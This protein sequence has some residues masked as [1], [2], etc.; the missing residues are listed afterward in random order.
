MSNESYVN[1]LKE[2]AMKTISQRVTDELED[3]MTEHVKQYWI[4]IAMIMKTTE[5]K[6]EVPKL[7]LEFF[8]KTPQDDFSFMKL[9]NTEVLR[10]SM[11]YLEGEEKIDREKCKT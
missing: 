8:S 9:M 7:D 10:N 5:H 3:K 11:G 4:Q 2:E 6:V 1:H